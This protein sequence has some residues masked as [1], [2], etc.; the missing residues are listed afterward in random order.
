MR[1]EVERERVAVLGGGP[2]A[3]AAAFELTATAA[4]RERFEVTVYQPGWRL[5]GKCASGRNLAKDCGGRIEE[6]GLHAWF[7]FYENAFRIMRAAY[8]E[9]GRAPGH[10]LAT[11]EDAFEGCDDFILYDRQGEGWHA[12][13]LEFPRNDQIP[14]GD[15]GLPDLWEI[16][17]RGC[18]W[19][20][21]RWEALNPGP[22][23]ASRAQPPTRFAPAWFLD[24]ARAAAVG[25]GA[26]ADRGGEHLLHAARHLSHTRSALGGSEV[27]RLLSHAGIP[28]PGPVKY[29]TPAHL[30]V[31]LLSRFRD[32][33]WEHIVRERF[34]EEPE[35]RLFFTIFDTFASA[36]AGIVEDGVLERGWDAIND[37]EL[38]EWLALHGAK[39]VTV[40]AT[41][42]QRAAVLRAFYDA[43]FA[44][45]GGVIANANLAAGTGISDILR[46]LF[47]YR[48]SFSYRMQAGMADTVLTPFYEVLERR[49]VK[50]EFF[51]AVCDLHL[52]E[53]GAHLDAIDVVPQVELNAPAYGPLVSVNGLEC[54]PSEPLWG[55]LRDGEKL[56]ER[57]VNF[58]LDPNPLGREP[59]TLRRGSDFDHAVLGIPVGALPAICGEIAARHPRFA[60]M[61]SSAAT[62]RTQAFQLWLTEPTPK[63]GWAH[64]TNSIVTSYVEP[65][66]TFSDMTHLLAREAWPAADGVRGLAYFCGILDDRP[67]EDHTAAT[68]R[69]KAN[70]RSFLEQDVGPI[71]PTALA[72]PGGSIDWKL[73]A[74]PSEGRG[75]ARL[76]AQY[77]RAN[78]TPSE[79]YVLTPAKSVADR[80]A[81]GESGVENL[82]LAGDWTRNGVDAGC[83]EAAMTSGIQAARALIGDPRPLTGA[84]PMWLTAPR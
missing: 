46:M 28:T 23:G 7:G 75:P 10:P 51:H 42:A 45:P 73:L 63:L 70:V 61:L 9:L 84:S 81:A 69:V 11:L 27:S 35:L 59:R 66:D 5:G 68:D 77:W 13:N 19:A 62:V 30:L 43:A 16:A 82:V 4:L 21:A 80:L 33:I 71:W 52:S 32:W 31:L 29:A 76:A 25:A 48:G 57:G 8:Q 22:A 38:C 64:S 14:G 20:V 56:A 74:D 15:Q 12:F 53:D 55:Q 26:D 44:Y 83:V 2:A 49:G 67:G 18:D 39:Q 17:A 1:T 65:L 37:L 36:I 58:E 41:P 34:A 54:W 78:T 3:I 50:F 47:T 6:H 72:G 79:L 40:G 24:I 60:R